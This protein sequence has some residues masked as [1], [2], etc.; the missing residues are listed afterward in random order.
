VISATRSDERMIAGTIAELPG[1]L[2]AEQ[3]A[4][5]VVVMIGHVFDRL[6]SRAGEPAAPIQR[7]AVVGKAGS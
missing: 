2:A 5:P 7:P 4:G 3:L 6:Q 1:R